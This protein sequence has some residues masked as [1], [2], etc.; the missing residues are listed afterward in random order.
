MHSKFIILGSGISGIS[1]AYFLNKAGYESIILDI[2]NPL[3]GPGSTI[4]SAGIIS[5]FFPFAEEIR[6]VQNSLRFYEDL[7][8]S[9]SEK[10]SYLIL[11]LPWHLPML[12][13][14]LLTNLN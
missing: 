1:T 4:R 8:H 10:I 13:I 11:Q 3:H 5:H 9:S 7:L 12:I 6:I 2:N 14:A